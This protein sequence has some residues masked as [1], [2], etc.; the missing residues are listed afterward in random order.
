MATPQAKTNVVPVAGTKTLIMGGVGSGKT[1]SIRTLIDQGITPFVVATEPGIAATLGDIPPEKLKWRYI[2]PADVDWS[3][4][5]DSAN[6]INT[7]TIKMLANME[8]I[9][10]QKYNQFLQVLAT[11]AKFVDERTGEIFGPV[12]SWGTDRCLVMDSMSGLAVMAMDMVVGSKPMKSQADWGIAMDN[13]GKLVD[14]LCCSVDC[15]LVMTC[16][17]EREKDEI[18]GAIKLMPSTLGQ[19][20]SPKIPRFF[21]NVIE[22]YFDGKNWRWRTNSTQADLKA[23]HLPVANDLD[24]NFKAIIDNWKSK[25]G[26]IT[27]TPPLAVTK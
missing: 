20:L 5:L 2:K 22:S 25:G 24:P 6:K 18:S 21:D 7:L 9:N 16:H 15:H 8:G 10:K 12:D 11:L 26:T 19:K 13:L 3:D 27:Q 14:K 4:M 1:Y 23:R 17:P